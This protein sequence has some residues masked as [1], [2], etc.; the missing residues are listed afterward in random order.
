M[1]FMRLSNKKLKPDDEKSLEKFDTLNTLSLIANEQ[2]YSM[3][4]EL[5]QALI[6]FIDTCLDYRV[7]DQTTQHF[8]SQLVNSNDSKT[9]NKLT[10]SSVTGLK[11]HVVNTLIRQQVI[12]K[13][14][15]LARAHELKGAA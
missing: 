3:P 5:E 6:Q 8:I 15:E 7:D 10:L 13:M 4:D 12:L 1:S 11:T 14:N 9:E 2:D